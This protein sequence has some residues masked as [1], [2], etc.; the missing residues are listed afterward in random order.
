MTSTD[1]TLYTGLIAFVLGTVVAL[2]GWA[3]RSAAPMIAG[4]MIAVPTGVLSLI[5]LL[6]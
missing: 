6:P 4:L 1:V 5:M 2:R 3:S